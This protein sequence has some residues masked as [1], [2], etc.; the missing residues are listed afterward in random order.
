MRSSSVR[1]TPRQ[2]DL[3]RTG[4]QFLWIF[5]LVAG[6]SRSTSPVAG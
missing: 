5:L 4:E 2:K 6:Y 3:V 1:V